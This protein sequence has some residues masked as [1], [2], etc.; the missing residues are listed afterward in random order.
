MKPHSTNE[1]TTVTTV[2]A[3][4]SSVTRK[5]GGV[6]FM[7]GTASESISVLQHVIFSCVVFQ[8]S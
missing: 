2:R 8:I 3:F 6:H 7:E 1:Y 4:D 5:D